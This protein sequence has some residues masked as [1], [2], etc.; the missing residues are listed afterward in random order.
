MKTV[1]LF[2]GHDIG[3]ENVAQ[4]IIELSKKNRELNV[5]VE[6]GKTKNRKLQYEMQK[7]ENEVSLFFLC[8]F[9]DF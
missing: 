7:L 3:S 8:I 9:T 6:S 5:E 2:L 1:Y 4:K